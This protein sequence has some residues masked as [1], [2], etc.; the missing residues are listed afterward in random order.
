MNFKSRAVRVYTTAL[1]HVCPR[2]WIRVYTT[3]WYDVHSSC[4][5]LYC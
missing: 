5:V 2:E 4:I 3:G 1:Q